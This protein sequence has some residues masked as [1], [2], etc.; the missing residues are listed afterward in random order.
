MSSPRQR[1]P[2]GGKPHQAHAQIWH[3]KRFYVSKGDVAL[4]LFKEKKRKK[5]HFPTTKSCLLQESKLH[6]KLLSGWEWWISGFLI[7]PLPSLLD[8][9][10]CFGLNSAALVCRS[11]S[12]PPPPPIY[13]CVCFDGS[14]SMHRAVCLLC[15]L[16]GWWVALQRGSWWAPVLSLGLF[17]ITRYHK[18]DMRLDDEIR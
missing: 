8:R 11:L 18:T 2:S 1:S 9:A 15:S 3:T 5:I 10:G 4:V 12:P 13:F 16:P 14:V 6:N 7:T 17:C